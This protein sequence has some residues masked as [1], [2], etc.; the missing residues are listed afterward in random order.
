CAIVA[1]AVRT[2]RGAAVSKSYKI[3]A[4]PGDGIGREVV[5]EGMRVI[6]AAARRHGFSVAWQEFDWSCERY[7][8]TG[9]MMP[10]DG[11]ATLANFDSIYLGAV[12]YPG[13]PAP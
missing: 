10:E 5:P 3:A 1:L 12:R 13:G 2:T 7:S 9:R 4:I 8:R 11:M 6:E